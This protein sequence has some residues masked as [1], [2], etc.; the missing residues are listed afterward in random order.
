MFF[1]SIQSDDLRAIQ[2]PLLRRE[3][4]AKGRANSVGRVGIAKHN[5]NPD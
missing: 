4:I 5:D 2:D 1:A 3:R